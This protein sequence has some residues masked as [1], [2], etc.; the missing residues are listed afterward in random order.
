MATGQTYD[1][2]FKLEAVRLVQTGG[3]SMRQIAD[4]LGISLSALSRWCQD[5]AINGDRAFVGSGHQQP[6]AEEMCRLRRENEMLR[7]ERDILKKALAI[8]SRP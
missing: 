1:K 3:K 6:E 4:D 7:Q 8:F 5:A 2:T